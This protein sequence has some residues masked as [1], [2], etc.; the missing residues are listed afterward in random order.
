M[1]IGTK[2]V[3]AATM[4]S[5]GGTGVAIGAEEEDGAKVR[6]FLGGLIRV[7][8]VSGKPESA[9]R[10]GGRYASESLRSPK[11]VDE[12]FELVVEKSWPVDVDVAY[13]AVK[14]SFGFLTTEEHLRSRRIN[15]TNTDK[16]SWWMP[17]NFRHE[18]TPGVA[19]ELQQALRGAPTAGDRHVRF[20]I[21]KAG[22]GESVGRG[23]IERWPDQAAR[24]EL[25]AWVEERINAAEAAIGQ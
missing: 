25:E 20:E 19:Y 7:E 4:L 2:L 23:Y 24:A 5:M 17:D 6:R 13:L 1:K 15:P 18:I 3:L 10:S 9:T 21:E 8:D 11:T 14:R 16:E 12:M 22:V